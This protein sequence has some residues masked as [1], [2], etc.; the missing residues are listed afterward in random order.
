MALG[1]VVKG[2]L[3]GLFSALDTKAGAPVARSLAG[4]AQNDLKPS[5]FYSPN[6]IKRGLG[7]GIGLLKTGYSAGRE[8]LDP[9]LLKMHETTGISDSSGRY[10]SLCILILI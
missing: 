10:K 2:V 7:M 9:R 5:L 1:P 8:Q 3:K 6:P 4:N